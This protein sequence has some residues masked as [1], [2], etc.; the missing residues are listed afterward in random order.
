MHCFFLQK[1]LRKGRNITTFV[2]CTITE[3]NDMKK[4]KAIIE[5][6]SDGFYSAYCQ[7]EMFSGAGSSAQEAK[8]DLL[9]QMHLFKQAAIEDGFDYPKFLDKEYEVVCKYDVAS[10]LNYY[11][12]ILS[13]AGLEKITGINQKQ[14]WK[15]QRGIAQ[16]RAAQINRI[17]AGLHGLGNELSAVEL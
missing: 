1:H 5:R 6:A 15:Y 3:N 2:K 7:T 9:Q 10:I 11:S 14:L 16:P 4:I 8:N 12:G 13:L 17:L